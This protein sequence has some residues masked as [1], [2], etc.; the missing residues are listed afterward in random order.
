MRPEQIVSSMLEKDQLIASIRQKLD[1]TESALEKAQLGTGTKH[2]DSSRR[3]GPLVRSRGARQADHSSTPF[4]LERKALFSRV[5]GFVLVT[6]L[7]DSVGRVENAVYLDHQLVNTDSP[8]LVISY[9]LKT[10]MDWK[11]T[12]GPVR[13]GS[14]SKGLAAGTRTC[15]TAMK[16]ISSR[17]PHEDFVP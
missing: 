15:T 10:V 8:G 12:A 4:I 11:F 5:S 7:V 9:A 3:S 13:W 6:A 2:R 1:H 16:L 17:R 14:E